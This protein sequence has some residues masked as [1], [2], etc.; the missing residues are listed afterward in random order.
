MTRVRV[1]WFGAATVCFVLSLGSKEMAAS[2][3][4]ACALWDVFRA[5][6][7]GS[8]GVRPAP[9]AVVARLVRE[10]AVLYAAGIVAVALFAYYTI[11]IRKATTRLFGGDVEFWGGTP[12]NNLLTVPLT[13]T[14]YAKLA[15]WPRTLAAQY[16]GAFDPASGFGDPRVIPAILFVLGTIAVATYLMVATRHRLVGLGI[17]LFFVTLLPASQILPHHEIVADHYLYLPL[18]ALGIAL[19]GALTALER[20]PGPAWLRP[21]VSGVVVVALL[22][23]SVRTVERNRDFKDEATLWEATYAA[24]PESP[25]AAYNYGLVLTTRGDHQRAIPLYKQTLAAEPTFVK[26]YF[27]LASTYAGLGRYDAARAVYRDALASDLEETSRTWH[28]AS[29]DVLRSMY[30]TELAMLDAQSG[31]TSSA[32][33]E[34]A[35][36]LAIYPDLLRTEDFFATVVQMRGEL[37]PTIDA[38]RARVE[39]A[40][41]AL[42]DRL[43]LANLQWKA[44]RLDDAYATLTRALEL[45]PDDCLANYLVARYYRDVRPGAAPT[46]RAADEAFDRALAASLT[47]FDAETIRRAR[48][49]VVAGSIAG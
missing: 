6:E 32:R 22:A 46:P 26:A 30:R 27:N 41:D 24:V 20:A 19:A 28:L 29:A 1:A 15:V 5:T 21:A 38:Y 39:A 17:F 14:H 4:L 33:D 47:S 3:P 40:P 42:P 48:G 18:A 8:D 10:G 23:L 2:F 31:Q 34:L 11:F 45:K 35:S 25:R 9:R 43:V 16:Y 7:P 49:D 12:L 13:L 36:I 44:G 37:A